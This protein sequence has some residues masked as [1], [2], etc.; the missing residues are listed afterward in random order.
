MMEVVE[1]VVVI[2][3]LPLLLDPQEGQG[4]PTPSLSLPISASASVS[5]THKTGRAFGGCLKFPSFGT[6]CAAGGR[7]AC[8]RPQLTMH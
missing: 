3:T 1:E 4:S 7:L 6:A 8:L 2:C 5:Q